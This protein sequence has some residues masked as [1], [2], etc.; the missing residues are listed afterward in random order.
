[1]IRETQERYIGRINLFVGY[2]L[3]LGGV[4]GGAVSVVYEAA[5]TAAVE[6]NPLLQD[7]PTTPALLGL[8]AVSLVGGHVFQEFG[9][10][11]LDDLDRRQAATPVSE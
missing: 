6:H 10:Q 2:A 11:I 7:L 3:A 4:A 8:A 9:H 5:R 1:M